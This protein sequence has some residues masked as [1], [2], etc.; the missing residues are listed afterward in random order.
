MSDGAWAALLSRDLVLLL[1][2]LAVYLGGVIGLARN[3]PA[4]LLRS[5]AWKADV[6]RHPASSALTLTVLIALWPVSVMYLTWRVASRAWPP[7][8]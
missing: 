7:G 6:E 2:V 1:A 3:L 4:I 8:R 5:K